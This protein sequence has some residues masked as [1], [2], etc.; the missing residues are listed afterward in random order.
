MF[1]EL[2]SQVVNFLM[3]RPLCALKSRK[4]SIAQQSRSTKNATVQC[5][6]LESRIL[7]SAA[8]LDLDIID[9]IGHSSSDP[10]DSQGP[11]VE[12]LLT[13]FDSK[14]VDANASLQPATMNQQ[15]T[16]VVFVANDIDR[17]EQLVHSLRE[18]L[19]QSV[20]V[21]VLNS[22]EDGIGLI[23]K[24]LSS[25]SD[26]SAVHFITHGGD[27]SVSLG[28][29]QLSN[30]SLAAFAGAISTWGDALSVDADLLFYGCNLAAS[31]DG[32][33]LVESLHTLTKRDV[34]ASDDISGHDALGGDWDL[35][36]SVGIIQSEVIV[37]EDLANH[38]VVQLPSNNAPT[39]EDQAF[40]I[41]ENLSNGS[42][43]ASITATDPDS[44]ANGT[45]TFSVTGGT[46]VSA[47]DVDSAGIIAVADM[48]LLDF[49]T[50]PV[51]T[52][53]VLVTDGGSPGLTDSATITINLNDVQN[54]LIVDTATDVL[55]GD[56]ASIGE[57]LGK[58]GFGT[59]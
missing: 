45:L 50:A 11:H 4:Q 56:T 9:P 43:V 23:T 19:G 13:A 18:E 33:Q 27:G 54:F 29:S 47:F 14:L 55:D 58:P 35:E 17:Y 20:D 52:L 34:A 42:V 15:T 37:S 39:V 49:E 22:H 2:Q 1:S 5:L 51:F 40:N 3:R 59:V 12:W 8:P 41:D 31:S 46:G 21:V 53:D 16:E 10:A 44:G 48:T 25:Y 26:L 6:E 28:N 36:V 32:V 38:W 24:A 7:Y 30:D 57:L